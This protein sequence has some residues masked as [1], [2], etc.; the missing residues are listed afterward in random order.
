MSPSIKESPGATEFA[1]PSLWQPASINGSLVWTAAGTQDTAQTRKFLSIMARMVLQQSCLYFCHKSG[2]IFTPTSCS[3]L[4]GNKAT[5]NTI[6]TPKTNTPHSNHQQPH[7]GSMIPLQG[8]FTSEVR[9]KVSYVQVDC[10]N[11]WTE[12]LNLVGLNHNFLETE[13]FSL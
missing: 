8:A 9:P 1:F 2:S 5:P 6:I 4:W 11:C 10:A 13:H 3:S 7:Q 12:C